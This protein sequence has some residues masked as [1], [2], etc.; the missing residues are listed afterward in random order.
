MNED[1]LLVCE[2]FERGVGSIGS[3]F[4]ITSLFH[5][6][7]SP[8]ASPPTVTWLRFRLHH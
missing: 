2:F 1:Q 7:L 3:S 5:S 4:E 6:S 8:D